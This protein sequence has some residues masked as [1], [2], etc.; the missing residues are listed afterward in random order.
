MGN[1]FEYYESLSSNEKQKFRKRI[2][3]SCLI[4]PP[5]WYSWMQRRAIPKPSQKLISIELGMDLEK[6][7]PEQ[8]LQIVE[9][10]FKASSEEDYSHEEVLTRISE[11]IKKA[12]DYW[13]DVVAAKMKKSTK[14]VY[15]YASG[16]VGIKS[17]FHKDVLRYL[18]ELVGD[19]TK[20]VNK[21]LD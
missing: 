7:F 5:T 20:E 8:K 13:V 11:L 1:F 14:S 17:G 12:P 15:N 10:Q 6:L 21:Y 3:K 19:E 16:K 9:G 4:E 18:K 2:V